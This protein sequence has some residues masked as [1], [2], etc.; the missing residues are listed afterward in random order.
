MCVCTVIN[1]SAEDKTSG[2]KFFHGGSSASKAGNHTFLGTLLTQK[3]KIGQIGPRV[4]TN[5]PRSLADSSSARAEYGDRGQSPLTYLLSTHA[6]RQDVDISFTVRN[7]N[8]VSL[9]VLFVRLR[10]SPARIKLWRRQIL[11]GGSS[12]SCVGNLPF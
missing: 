12:V 2:V 6:D 11:H 10:I 7:F 9:F 4:G 5:W 3:P 8:C 1:F